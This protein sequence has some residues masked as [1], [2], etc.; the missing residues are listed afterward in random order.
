MKYFW[1]IFLLILS[2]GKRDLENQIE[3]PFLGKWKLSKISCYVN[4]YVLLE[5]YTLPSTVKVNLNY[6]KASFL[7]QVDGPGCSMQYSGDY[8]Y[9]ISSFNDGK[10]SFYAYE[11][12][13]STCELTL[14]E[15]QTG[16]P[17]P[18]SLYW[19]ALVNK[20]LFW[21]IDIE[22]NELLLPGPFGFKGGSSISSGCSGQC[23]CVGHY[24]I[25]SDI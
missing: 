10:Q 5:Q 23:L 9:S 20:D 13:S 18:V 21:R 4:N 16:T 2:C 1:P 15:D 7:Y 14:Q 12:A 22:N 6:I 17:V 19:S 3:N 8:F 25:S 11:G 24:K